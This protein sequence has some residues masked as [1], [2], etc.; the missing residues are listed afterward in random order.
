MQAIIKDVDGSLHD[1]ECHWQVLESAYDNATFNQA[2]RQPQQ[3]F[4][5]RRE[6]DSTKCLFAFHGLGYSCSVKDLI[7]C[8]AFCL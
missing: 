5:G 7:A 6:T 4:V 8:I 2:A 1:I 3:A